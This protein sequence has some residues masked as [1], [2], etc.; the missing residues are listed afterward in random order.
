M[1]QGP[2][3]AWNDANEIVKRVTHQ[4]LGSGMP[5]VEAS[6][7]ENFVFA[8]S[9]RRSLDTVGDLDLVVSDEFYQV[10][11]DRLLNMAYPP[12][13]LKKDSTVV[14]FVA[15]TADIV[16]V[17]IELYRAKPGMF[18]AMLLFATGAADF[19]IRQRAEARRRGLKLSQHALFEGGTIIAGKTEESIFEAMR[20]PFIP[21]AEREGGLFDVH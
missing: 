13:R 20:M 19:N 1:S 15:A 7:G 4:L 6:L 17:R 10:T 2:R 8:G 11:V 3:I 12:I 5:F 9:F 21:P 18:G 16:A 14:G